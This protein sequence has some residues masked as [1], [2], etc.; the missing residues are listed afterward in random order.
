LDIQGYELEALRGAPECL[1]AARAVIAEV[2]FIAYYDQQCLFHD[3][4]HH[5]AQAG[6]FLT[7][8]A[9]GTPT[10]RRLGQTDALFMRSGIAE[11]ER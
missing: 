11:P 4:V 6:L 10:G 2:S 1:A 7:A 3:L 9:F 8:L 5:L